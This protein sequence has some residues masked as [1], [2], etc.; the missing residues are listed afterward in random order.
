MLHE[1]HHSLVVKIPDVSLFVKHMTNNS[2]FL[3]QLEWYGLKNSNKISAF[4]NLLLDKDTRLS[5]GILLAKYKV[6]MTPMIKST[7]RAKLRLEIRSKTIRLAMRTW[8]NFQTR[9]RINF[10]AFTIRSEAM[11][12]INFIAFTIRL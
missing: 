9:I 8:M 3:E 2:I 10:I 1:N 4:A 11:I 5:S 7:I 6:L 12:W